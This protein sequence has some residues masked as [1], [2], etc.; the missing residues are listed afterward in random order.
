LIGAAPTSVTAGQVSIITATVTSGSIP[1]SGVTVTFTLPVAFN[2]SGAT[3][4]SSTAVTDGAG[5][6]VV[7]Y[8]PGITS[9]TLTVQDTVQAE[10]G[11]AANT[12]VITRTGS[13][14][15]AYS[16]TV[17]PPVP[18]TVPIAGGSSVITANVKTNAG[19]PISGV[20]V[21]FTTI[22]GT[23]TGG[24]VTASATTDGSGN[25]VTVFTVGPGGPVG[26]TAG[27]VTASITIAGNPYTDA[28]VITY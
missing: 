25:A 10:I 14:T 2:N 28:V 7:V 18:A 4:S 24:G 9:P 26:T 16:I 21:N 27:I 5:N 20:T 23:L 22:G 19:T 8:Q 12:V 6:A 15:S 17:G 3:L 11:T 13:A 1:A